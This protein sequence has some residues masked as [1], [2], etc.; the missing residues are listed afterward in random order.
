[1]RNDFK[2]TKLIPVIQQTTMITFLSSL[3]STLYNV[4]M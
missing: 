3:F 4:R 2:V 1:L